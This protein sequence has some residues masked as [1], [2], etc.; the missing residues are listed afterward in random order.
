MGPVL[1]S[2]IVDGSNDWAMPSPPLIV[3]N[4]LLLRTAQVEIN[5]YSDVPQTARCS[6]R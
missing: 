3:L 6:L 5:A 4:D 1:S 2:E